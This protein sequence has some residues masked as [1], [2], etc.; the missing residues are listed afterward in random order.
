[1]RAFRDIPIR[2]KLM[3]VIVLTSGVAIALAS[4]L[5]IGYQIVTARLAAVYDLRS[6]A[7]IIAV[8]SSEELQLREPRSAER[9]LSTLK[10]RPEVLVARILDRDG[11]LFAQY[12]R[13]GVDPESLPV[14]PGGESYLFEGPH[15]VLSHR[16]L[17]G[18]ETIGT[19]V[20]CIDRSEAQLR[21]RYSIIIVAMLM[22]AAVCIALL[23]AARLQ[24]VVSG[25]IRDL[26]MVARTV[27]VE[28]N[29]SLRARHETHDETGMLVNTFNQMLDQIQQ[30]DAE[31]REAEAKYRLLV[32]QMPAITYTAEL[33]QEGRWHYISP[34]VESLLGFS[35]VEWLEQPGLWLS[36]LHPED[37]ALAVGA[38]EDCK[39]S[40]RLSAE[41]RML[42]RD[43]HE[44]WVRDEGVVV[45][46]TAERPT[47][48]Q[49]VIQDITERKRLEKKILEVSDRE[50]R[51]IGQDLHD[52][53]CQLLTATTFATKALQQKLAEAGN[54][55][56]KEAGEIA[57]LLRRANG[58]ARKVARGL[59]PVE[60]ESD[61]LT[62]ALRELSFNVQSLFNIACRF[63]CG[64]A[65]ALTDNSK[66]VHVYRIAQE[67]VNNALKH[68]HA[69]HIGI[70]L[71][72]SNGSLALTVNDDG[73]GLP[74]QPR[75][76]R[77]MGLNIMAYRARMIG[78]ALHVRP[79]AGGGTVVSLVFPNS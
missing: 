8:N 73:I 16:I 76:R 79:G 7:D 25:P 71:T 45:P 68:S 22:S 24:E 70:I 18:G 10:T 11:N 62:A 56:A 42:T 20:L 43:G 54:V 39:T 57:E 12:A 75:E 9:T 47:V 67:A 2:R 5:I 60:L 69:K 30:R 17:A 55:E 63:D 36:Q 65:I 27:A 48:I 41:Y 59:H 50:Q 66:A 37:R 14:N 3:L 49:G 38:E 64:P 78:G 53:L 4:A 72:Q 29:Y 21:L 40:G 44:V 23:L 19:V 46:G 61:G 1:M 15:L 33:G 32:E 34:Q 13:A 52:G 58:D 6:A 74:S 51:R 26:A 35:P 31:L 77:G 28:K